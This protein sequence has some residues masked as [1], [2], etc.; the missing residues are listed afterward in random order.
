MSKFEK[1]FIWIYNE[2]IQNFDIKKELEVVKMIIINF[3]VKLNI[4]Q[5]KS[6]FSD[7][8]NKFIKVIENTKNKYKIN[9]FSEDL[10]RNI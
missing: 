3:T 7:E 5:Q 9:C 8:K 2:D 4:L 1:S 10:K 6:F